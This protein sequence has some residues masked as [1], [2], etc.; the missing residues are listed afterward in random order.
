MYYFV[1]YSVRLLLIVGTRS[2][3]LSASFPLLA[4]FSLVKLAAARG[5]RS[6]RGHL[7]RMSLN[8]S[9]R[10]FLFFNEALACA[11]PRYRCAPEI[12]SRICHVPRSLDFLYFDNLSRWWNGM[13]RKYRT[14][15]LIRTFVKRVALSSCS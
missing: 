2:N 13:S 14:T 7:D 9:S 5:C 6:D 12:L 4:S 11:R 1:L 15:S 3:R 8:A 10:M